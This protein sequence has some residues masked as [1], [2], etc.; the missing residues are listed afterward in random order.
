MKKIKICFLTICLVLCFSVTVWARTEGNV[1]DEAK[2]FTI[3]QQQNLTEQAQSLGEE[4]GLDILFLTTTDTQGLSAKE[5][6]AQ[7]FIDGDFGFGEEKSGIVFVID[8]KEHDAQMVTSGEAIEIYTDDYISQMWENV[9]PYL[10]NGA[11]H[12]GMTVFLADVEK[13]GLAYQAY[14]EDPEHTISEYQVAQKQTK[15][16]LYMGIAVV[17]SLAVA[18]ISVF[19]MKQGHKNVKPYT[20]GRAYLKENGMHIANVQDR[21][22]TTHT[23]C[24]RIQKDNDDDH[25][26][27]GG[28]SST[29]QVDNHD[30][31]GGGGKF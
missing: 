31:G 25:S 12:E 15:I 4:L 7:F 22:L 16:L 18:G 21:F 29:F 20:D 28:D 13:Y 14:L 17:V 24:T 23:V 6:G 9:K 19:A 30:F 8:M 27:W 11:Y 10:A 1:F 26:S 5:Y 3:E 2:L